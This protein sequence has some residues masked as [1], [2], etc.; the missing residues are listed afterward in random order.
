MPLCEIWPLGGE[1]GLG[2]V[3]PGAIKFSNSPGSLDPLHPLCWIGYPF[4]L[5]QAGAGLIVAGRE[6]RIPARN[7]AGPTAI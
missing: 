2:S 4:L 3:T 5:I 6:L 7:E 1:G